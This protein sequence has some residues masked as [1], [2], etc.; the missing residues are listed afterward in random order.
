[1]KK[2]GVEPVIII[3]KTSCAARFFGVASVSEKKMD[4]KQ[5]MAARLAAARGDKPAGLVF[6]GG[7]VV[8][9]FTGQ[10]EQTDLAVDHG[11]I[12]GLGRYEGEEV[13]DLEGAFVAPGFIDGHL[14]IES[15][16]LAPAQFAKAVCPLGTSAV[17]ADPHEITN[18]MGVEGFSAMIDASENLP[19][20]IFFMASSCVPASPLQDSGAVLSAAELSLLGRHPRVLGLAEMM[21]FP[22]TMAGA[23]DILDKLGAFRGRPVDGHAPLLRGKGLNAYICAGPDSDHECTR[24]NEAAEKLSK[25]MWLMIRQGTHA[26]N[27][28]DLLPLVTPITER[29]CML[30]SDDRQADTIAQRGHMDDLLRLAVDGGIDPVTAIRLVTLN[31]AARFGLHGRGALA[32]GYRADIVV[33]ED[34][35][36]FQVSRVY[37]GGKLVA[38]GGRCLHPCDQ[39]FTPTARQTMHLPELTPQLF[40]VPV[41]GPKVRVIEL[42]KDQ[43]ITGQALEQTP[44]KGGYLAAD[45]TSDLALAYVIERHKASGDRGACLLRG[46]G[47]KS[48]ALATS[49][50]HD[51]HNLVLA[52]TDEDSLLVAARAVAEMG[53]GLAVAKEG[54]VLA[55]LPLPLAGLMSDQPY[56][57]VA[58]EISD[59]DLA[60]AQVCRMPSPFMVL[61]FIALEVIPHL[62]LTGRGLVDVDQFKPLD[63]FVE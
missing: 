5:T 28:K 32:P 27:L 1:M 34:L 10:I 40:R 48:G 50:A 6:T 12:V 56:D 8:N 49:V 24:Y 61:S 53:G 18:V 57:H 9:V 35:H 37:H 29:R 42:F 52:G 15:S 22:G 39:S 36:D 54:R 19:V 11:A 3:A 26:H 46:L 2:I 38:Q 41:E 21:N 47:F 45:P 4:W 31:P 60:A 44:Q 43:I 62:K 7:N 59:I 33:L 14:H 51:C 63:L 58:A 30:V 23:P 13:I 20:T 25:G 16:L 17:V 55:K